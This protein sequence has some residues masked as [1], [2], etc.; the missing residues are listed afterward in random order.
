MATEPQLFWETYI[1]YISLIEKV[2][3]AGEDGDNSFLF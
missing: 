2:L 1:I 3:L